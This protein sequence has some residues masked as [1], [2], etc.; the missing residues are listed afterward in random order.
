MHVIDR[1]N[2]N[3]VTVALHMIKAYL[4]AIK[5]GSMKIYTSMDKM[6]GVVGTFQN[7]QTKDVDAILKDC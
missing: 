7:I 4:A 2:Y 3:S 5:D 6:F 1:D